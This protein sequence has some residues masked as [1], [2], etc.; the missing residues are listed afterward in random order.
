MPQ[1]YSVLG[2]KKAPENT[3]KNNQRGK[4]NFRSFEIKLKNNKN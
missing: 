3:R 2:K 1:G 4:E